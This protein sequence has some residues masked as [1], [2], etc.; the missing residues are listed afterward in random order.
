MKGNPRRAYDNDGLEIKP[1]TV[2]SHMVL[3]SVEK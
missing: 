3:I 2:A 1:A